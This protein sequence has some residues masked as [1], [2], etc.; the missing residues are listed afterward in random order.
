MHATGRAGAKL[1]SMRR[2]GAARRQGIIGQE[3]A[4]FQFQQIKSKL[5]YKISGRFDFI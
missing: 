4:C 1:E 3:I 2:L 5:I